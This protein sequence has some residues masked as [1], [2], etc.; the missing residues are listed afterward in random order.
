MLLS[1]SSKATTGWVPNAEPAVLLLGLVVKASFVAAPAENTMFPLVTA[2][3]PVSPAVAVAVN[4]MVSAF[5]Y[6]TPEIVSLFPLV[7]IVPANVPLSVPPPDAL[8]NVMVVLLVG[9]EGLPFA[10][11]DCGR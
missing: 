3:K 10:S 11:C 7:V 4:V 6:T 9:L 1:A 8:L 2:V 5:E